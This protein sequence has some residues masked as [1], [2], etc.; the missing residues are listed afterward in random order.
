MRENWA[1]VGWRIGPNQFF[2][3]SRRL[4]DAITFDPEFR[5]THSLRLHEALI[6]LFPSITHAPYSRIWKTWRLEWVTKVKDDG[7]WCLDARWRD[8]GSY[9]C[10]ELG[11]QRLKDFKTCLLNRFD[12]AS[13]RL[14]VQNFMNRLRSS[15]FDG[16]LNQFTNVAAHGGYRGAFSSG[17]G[18]QT[19][20]SSGSVGLAMITDRVW[21][22][23]RTENPGVG[24]S[25]SVYSSDFSGA[26]SSLESWRSI[27]GTPSV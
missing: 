13:S 24:D 20:A 23:C 5:L 2:R 12:M 16:S 21:R 1:R 27:R 18:Y 6:A 17:P 14:H 26:G 10:I 8:Q 11:V 7:K 9:V 15:R 3:R 22:S 4:P 19:S 25:H